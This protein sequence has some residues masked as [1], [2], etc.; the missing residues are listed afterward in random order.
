MDSIKEEWAEAYLLENW[1]NDVNALT[2]NAY[3]GGALN[4]GFY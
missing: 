3:G 1:V 4:G 2:E